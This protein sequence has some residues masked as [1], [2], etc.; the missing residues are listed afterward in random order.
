MDSVQYMIS[1]IRYICM[2]F[3]NRSGG[4]IS[5]RHC[6]EHI[7]NELRPD[8]DTIISQSFTVHPDAGWAWITIT[9]ALGIGSIL[10][11]LFGV[12]N[13]PLAVIGF[14]ASVLAIMITVFQFLMGYCLIDPLF[15]AKEA[16]NVYVGVEPLND[17]KQR[18]VFAGHA[19][20]AYE[21]T[22][23]HTGGAKKVL[24]VAYT[25]LGGLAVTSLLNA[26]ILVYLFLH[27]EV[28]LFGVWHWLR[29]ASLLFL[30][31]FIRTLFFFNRRCIVDGA[32]D[33]LSGCVVAMAVFKQFAIPQMRLEHTEVGCLITSSEECG[34]RGARAFGKWFAQEN[35]GVETLFVVL[36][37]LH[38]IKQLQVYTHGLNGFQKNSD[39]VA[40]L[41]YSS[42]RARDI[43]ISEA[44]SYLGATDAEALSREG[45]LACALCAVDHTPQ[46]YYHTREDNPDNI[47]GECLR[48][49]LDI[50]LEAAR[51]YDKGAVVPGMQKAV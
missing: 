24:R 32:N 12:Q 30:P 8:A 1:Q 46:P 25:A 19:D 35:D 29:L 34:L 43:A 42:A 21:M 16:R 7:A 2:T 6:Q 23:S 22:Y 31:A 50:C 45:L 15:P 28:A 14:S 3:K 47:S 17:T 20:A 38:D 39:K 26:T 37:T 36:D 51:E 44:G 13:K 11:P 9:A 4:S 27:G 40:E 48:A 18:I 41:L 33:N 5:E 10:V 49:C